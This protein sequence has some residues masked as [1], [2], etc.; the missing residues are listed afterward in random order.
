M[1]NSIKTYWMSLESRERL[2]LSWGAVAVTGILF[3]ALIWQP[4]QKALSVR[5]AAV[6]QLRL[7][8]VWVT[9]QSEALGGGGKSGKKSFKGADQSLLSVIQQSAKEINVNKMI[10][11]MVPNQTNDEVRVALEG[12]DF[13]Q[14]VKWVDKLYKDYGVDITSINAEKDDEKPNIAEIRVTFVRL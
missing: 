1:S 8:S 6:H 9:Q 10:Q 5:E 7:D 13:N 12:V 2:V 14:W 3:Y 4:W 11:Q